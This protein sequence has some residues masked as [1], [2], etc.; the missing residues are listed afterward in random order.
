MCLNTAEAYLVQTITDAVV[1]VLA[2]F[3]VSQ[4]QAT[5]DAGKIA[6]FNNLILINEP[7]AVAYGLDK[8][9]EN[10]QIFLSLLWVVGMLRYPLL[11]LKMKSSK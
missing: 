1:S 4:R 8:K 11:L 3:N 5:I 7:A 2:C 10:K 6:G 9:F